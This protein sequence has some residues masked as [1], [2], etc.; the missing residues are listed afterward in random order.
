ML[1][2]ENL[3]K[4]YVTTEGT[5]GGGVF[6]ADFTVKEGELF[7]LLGP[8]G[9]GKT[10]TLRSIAGLERPQSGRITLDGKAIFDS[11]K[12]INV[13][14]YKRDIGMVFQSYA[15]WPHMTVYQNAAYPLEVGKVRKLSSSEIRKRVMDTLALVGLQDFASRPAPQL[16]GGQQ[17]RLALARALTR[18][19]ALLL[20]DEPLS[21]LDAQLREQ[22]RSELK[23]L[24]RETGV[25][26]IYVTHD[27][28]EALAIS[29]RIAVMKDGLIMQLGKPREIYGRPTSEFVA[30]FI[31]RTNLLHGPLEQNVAKGE[32]HR[33]VT[34]LGPVLC[35]FP[36]A[37]EKSPRIGVVIRPEDIHIAPAGSDAAN[38]FPEINRFEGRI[39]SEAYLGEIVEFLVAIGDYEIVVRTRADTFMTPGSDT[40]VSFPVAHTLALIE[41]QPAPVVQAA[42]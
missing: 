39:I 16:S 10:T 17:Q 38:R 28:A 42:E 41:D 22:M 29:D 32:E 6:G 30:E 24:Q 4:Q 19:P 5:P 36:A 8:S 20:L 31:G 26:A 12:R 25:T 9:C 13:P 7:T 18:T 40:V 34:G 23:R 15:I 21:N 33:I 2:V 1:D 27:Q 11:H 3:F 35:T 14:L 37:V